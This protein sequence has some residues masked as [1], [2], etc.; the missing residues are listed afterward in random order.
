MNLPEWGATLLITA[1]IG[2]VVWIVNRV[3][4]TDERRHDKLDTRISRLEREAVTKE[5]LKAAM[6]R[7][8]DNN[9]YIRGRVDSILKMMLDGDDHGT[10]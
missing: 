4:A 1:I 6:D 9:Q 8:N 2:L 5:E 10:H 7:V 3:L